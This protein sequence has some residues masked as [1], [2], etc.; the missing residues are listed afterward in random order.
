MNH[1]NKELLIQ[2]SDSD[3]IIIFDS[4]NNINKKFMNRFMNQMDQI[5]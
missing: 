4:F 5:T 2:D 1:S 3:N